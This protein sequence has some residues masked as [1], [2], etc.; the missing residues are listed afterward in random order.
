MSREH[1]RDELRLTYGDPCEGGDGMCP[2]DATLTVVDKQSKPWRV[3]EDH[4][5]YVLEASRGPGW[6]CP[7]CGRAEC[8]G[9]AANILG[10]F[11]D[12][13]KNG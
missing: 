10:L 7:V 13:K 5:R 9:H 6:R 4:A 12:D 8:D 11:V 3:C 1:P 2:N